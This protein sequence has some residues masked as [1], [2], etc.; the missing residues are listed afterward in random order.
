MGLFTWLGFKQKGKHIPER[1][2]D[3]IKRICRVLFIDDHAFPV[4][5]ILKESGWSSTGRIRDVESLDQHEIR[6][7]HVIF[8]D[9]QGIGRKLK[10]LDSTHKRNW[11]D[12]QAG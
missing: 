7:A 11:I 12:R 6:D 10:F 1:N 4:I 3:E 9:I 8:V 2:I 5:D